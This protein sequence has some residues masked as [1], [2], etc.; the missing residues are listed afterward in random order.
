MFVA[1][2][3]SGLS[4]GGLLASIVTAIAIV[5]STALAIVAVVGRKE[6]RSFAIGFLIPVVA[7]S[8]MLLSIGKSELDPYA[9]KLP[10]TKLIRPAFEMIVKI[11]YVDFTTGEAL[12]DYDPAANPGLGGG[13]FGGVGIREIPDRST[14]MSLAH[15]I[16]AM[17]CGYI[18]AKFAVWID[19]NHADVS[20]SGE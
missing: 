8:A 13:G 11:E 3:I 14:F 1:L 19:R 7:Y 2:G 5:A 4:V 9:G 18:G 12:P 20:T 16:L 15:V 6:L 17:I 10:T